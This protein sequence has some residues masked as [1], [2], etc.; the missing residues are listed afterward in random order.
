M[1]SPRGRS[2]RWVAALLFS[3][4]AFCTAGSA[5]DPDAAK[6]AT[7]VTL[8]KNGRSYTNDPGS[9][10]AEAMLV[11]GDEILATG[12]DDEVAALADKGAMAVDLEKHFV[13]PGFNDAHVH[14]G[15]AGEYW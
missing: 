3:T 8:Y 5:Q 9:P 14:L 13:M 1:S 7:P 15:G 2:G 10:W 12:D 4:L 6:P 11:R